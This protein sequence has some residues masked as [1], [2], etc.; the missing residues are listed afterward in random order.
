MAVLF[1]FIKNSKALILN[2]SKV[3][4]NYQNFLRFGLSYVHH[5]KNLKNICFYLNKILFLL[6]MDIAKSET[7]KNFSILYQAL[8]FLIV[9]I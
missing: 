6:M 5:Q 3:N 9:K 4:L 1:N 2:L 7:F 8:L